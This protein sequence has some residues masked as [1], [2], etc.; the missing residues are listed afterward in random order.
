[1][2]AEQYWISKTVVIDWALK[3]LDGT[4]ASDATVAGTI[5]RPDNTTAPITGTWIAASSVWRF[6]YDPSSAGWHGYRITA[7]GTADSAEEGD[8]YVKPSKTGSLPPTLDPAT[9]IGQVRLLIPDVDEDNLLFTDPQVSGFLTLEGESVRLAAAQ[10]LDVIASNEAMISK[11]I[12][13]QNLQTDGA[14][15][16]Q[17]LMARATSL[18]QQAAEGYGD[19]DAGFAIVDYDPLTGL[20]RAE[21][22][23]LG[24]IS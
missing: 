6:T 18:R 5:T 3:K 17:A 9:T 22:A 19:D 16:A 21:L 8:F 10:A 4:A 15:L 1:M 7:T 24:I 11:V 20:T 2:T 12:R 13:T 23:E 14:K